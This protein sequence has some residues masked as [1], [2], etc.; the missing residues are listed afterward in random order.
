MHDLVISYFN[1]IY[2]IN[3]YSI[4][5]LLEQDTTKPELLPL[6]WISTHLE[7]TTQS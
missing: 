2:L 5:S 6:I 1:F 3:D 4:I 7:N